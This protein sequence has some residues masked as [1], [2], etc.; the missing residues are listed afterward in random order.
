MAY[1]GGRNECRTV[2]GRRSEGPWL[3]NGRKNYRRRRRR[4]RKRRG[5]GRC[6]KS[7]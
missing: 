5:E 2:G 6:C 7:P 4:R 3:E 1:R